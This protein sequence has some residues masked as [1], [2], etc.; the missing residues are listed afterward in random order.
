VQRSN[1]VEPLVE[2]IDHHQDRVAI[3]ESDVLDARQRAQHAG[4]VARWQF[5]QRAPEPR[6][7]DWEC[8]RSTSKVEFQP[9]ASRPRVGDRRAASWCRK[10]GMTKGL[11]IAAQTGLLPNA[12]E[13]I[14]NRMVYF[15]QYEVI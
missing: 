14:P 5:T 10:N 12:I 11:L 9:F 2:R 3:F 13:N 7:S 4:N 1:E 6:L 15:C 8:L